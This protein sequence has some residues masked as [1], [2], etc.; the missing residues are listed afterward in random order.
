MSEHSNAPFPAPIANAACGL[1]KPSSKPPIGGSK[2]ADLNPY[3]LNACCS[4]WDQ[5]VLTKDF[6]TD[7]NTG[8]PGTPS[9]GPTAA[10]LTAGPELATSRS[11]TSKDTA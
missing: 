11:P 7:T 1:Q 3:P 5:C 4:I 9:P 6:C 2:I 8:S 10:S